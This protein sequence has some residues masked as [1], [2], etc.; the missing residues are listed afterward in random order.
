MDIKKIICKMLPANK[1]KS[2]RFKY[3]IIRQKF[4]K[5]MSEDFFRNLLVQKLGIN[6][7]DTLFIHSSVDFLNVNFS[8]L[9]LLKILIDVTGKEGTLIFPAWHISVRAEEYLQN[10]NNIFDVKRSPSVLGFLPE[11]ARRLPGAQR[12]LHPINSIVAIGKNA[13]EIISGHEQS[14]Y[15][16]G[17]SSPYYKMLKYNAKII[18]IGVNSNFLSFLHCPED[19]MKDDFPMQTRTDESYIGRVRLSTNEIIH[20]RT[21][22]AHKNIQKCNVPA[23]LRKYVPKNIFSAY[24]IRGSEFFIADANALFHK[25]IELAKR[26]IMTYNS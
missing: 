25:T 21:L 26:N 19:I 3:R 24:Q 18:G 23:F 15:P 10:E 14:I 13:K 22:A 17:E 2:I 8:P 4:H 5:Q 6:E 20:V 1:I 7:G 9:Q 12:S 11:L 16:C